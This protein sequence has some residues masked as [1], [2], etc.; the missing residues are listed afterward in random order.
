[1]TK[2]IAPGVKIVTPTPSRPKP[3]TKEQIALAEFKY[4]VNTWFSLMDEATKR[5]AVA[6]AIAKA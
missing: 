6:Y 1:M 5:E 4:S 3:K 2:K